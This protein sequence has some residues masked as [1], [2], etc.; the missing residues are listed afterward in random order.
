VS[1]LEP[2]AEAVCNGLSWVGYQIVD[3]N[4]LLLGVP[5]M[6]A[7]AVALIAWRGK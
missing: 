2:I 1:V 5:L 3:H 7:G 6:G 4:W